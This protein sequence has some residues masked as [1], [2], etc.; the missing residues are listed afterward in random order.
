MGCY[1]TSD[2]DGLGFRSSG[3]GKG[4]GRERNRLGGGSSQLA[5]GFGQK[6]PVNLPESPWGCIKE[7]EGRAG[8]LRF[9][10]V[11]GTLRFT[12]VE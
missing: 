11:A 9:T 7:A 6:K 3:L 12:E 4:V 1:A 10:E 2:K 8:T 5:I